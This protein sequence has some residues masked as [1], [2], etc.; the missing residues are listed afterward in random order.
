MAHTRSGI[1]FFQLPHTGLYASGHRKPEKHSIARLGWRIGS[2]PTVATGQCRYILTICGDSL[3]DAKQTIHTV[4]REFF[5][6]LPPVPEGD[7]PHAC[8]LPPE[9]I[10]LPPTVT[11]TLSKGAYYLDKN[12]WCPFS[13]FDFIYASLAAIESSPSVFRELMMEE[14]GIWSFWNQMGLS[15]E[16]GPSENSDGMLPEEVDHLF[17]TLGDYNELATPSPVKMA[18][19]RAMMPLVR[20]PPDLHDSYADLARTCEGEARLTTIAELEDRPAMSDQVEGDDLIDLD[21][22]SAI[23][24]PKGQLDSPSKIPLPASTV[25][26]SR[27][28]G[29]VST[30]QSTSTSEAMEEDELFCQGIV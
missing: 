25:K 6:A 22:V 1:L 5:R 19:Y 13:D 16:E 4:T 21:E 30:G 9:C 27:S 12:R 26:A 23:T 10:P 14:G 15:L 3:T 28:Q 8:P 29:A 20:R 24:T 11:R 2:S 18:K 17:R 7:A